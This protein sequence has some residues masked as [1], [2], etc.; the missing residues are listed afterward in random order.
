MGRNGL[1][2]GWCQRGGRTPLTI[3]T[4]LKKK[5]QKKAACTVPPILL[6]PSKRT[7][8]EFMTSNYCPFLI[9]NSKICLSSLSSSAL[10]PAILFY[11]LCKRNTLGLNR[12]VPERR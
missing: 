10:P 11:C 9:K 4:K 1:K 8:I 5:S 3:T 2:M 12:G 7:E 6:T